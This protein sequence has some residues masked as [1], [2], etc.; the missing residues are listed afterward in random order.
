MKKKWFEKKL[1]ILII[2][3]V[4]TCVF[5]AGCGEATNNIYVDGIEISKKNLYLAEGQTAV[6]SAQVYPFNAYNQNYSFESSNSSIV[7]CEDGFVVAKKAGEAMIYVYSEEGGYKDSCNVLVTTASNNLELNNYNNLNMPPKELEPIYNSEDYNSSQ[8]TSAQSITKKNSQKELLNF[9]NKKNN[10]SKNNEQFKVNKSNNEKNNQNLSSFSK[11]KN[12][13]AKKVSAEFNSDI[14]AGKK[15]LKNL[16]SDLQDSIL[17]MESQKNIFSSL[18][19]DSQ[20]SLLNAFNNLNIEI[21]N[22]ISN[23]KQ[24]I[25]NN[26][27]EFEDKL[28][29]GE[30]TVETK[31]ING[32]TFVMIKNN[33]NNKNVENV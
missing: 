1:N 25:L 28:D 30:Y 15:I 6:I 8:T 27:V 5:I 22:E 9:L 11:F 26:L 7:T 21:C 24:S 29:S 17:N 19:Q 18:F 16:K 20:S 23:T 32:V 4:L 14:E 12:L 2:F 13:A 3:L 33:L 31:D 10:K